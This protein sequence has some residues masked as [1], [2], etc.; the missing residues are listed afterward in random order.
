MAMFLSYDEAKRV[1]RDR[2]HA[3]RH[4]YWD[5]TPPN[6]YEIWKLKQA[7][8]QTNVLIDPTMEQVKIFFLMV[9]ASVLSDALKWGFNDS[10]V[11]TELYDYILTNKATIQEALATTVQ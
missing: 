9:P 2:L 11:T 6:A 4:A 7:L 1:Q 5:S 10:H 3:V 8:M